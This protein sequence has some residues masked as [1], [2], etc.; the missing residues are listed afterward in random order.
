[1]STGVG[2][3]EGDSAGPVGDASWR[4]PAMAAESHR[5]TSFEIFFDL[6]FVFAITR[7]VSFMARSLTAATLAQGLI[8]LLLLWWSWAAY[9]WLGNRVRTDQGVVRAGMLVVM[10]AL[11]I[12]ALVMPDAWSRRTGTV[13][14]PLILAAA[15]IVVRL[16]YFGL[17]LTAAAEDSGLRV[18]LLA[19]AIPQ[20]LSLVPLIAGAVLAGTWQTALWSVAF[21]IDFG[22]GWIASRVGGWRVRSPGHFAERH[23]MVLIIVL[24]ESL[25]SAGAGAGDSVTR[26][27]VLVAAV[28]GFA[29]VVCLWRLYFERLAPAAEDTLEH[30]SPARRA[31]IA[32]DAYTM[33][34]FL[35]I[36]GILYL[37]LGAREVLTAVTDSRASNLGA[38]LS[39]PASTALYAGTAGY[40][41]GRAA[42]TRLTVRQVP[43]AQPAAAAALLILLPVARYL[44]ALA[45]LAVVSATLI[46]L[47]AFEGA[48][49]EPDDNRENAD[50]HRPTDA[51]SASSSERPGTGW[52]WKQGL[53]KGRTRRS[54][55][56]SA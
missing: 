22:G 5:V 25:I 2:P 32:R 39:W 31:R 12:A 13:D 42:F 50:T 14:A 9:V 34:H 44:P 36:A 48:A 43:P 24:G 7:V 26:T 29:A 47:T 40:L 56:P 4:R 54:A 21:A 33:V 10:A 18:Q 6:V 16:V 37:A 17:Y 45:A 28:L 8:L 51:A 11:F 3:G 41:A 19:D 30:A 20:T 46:A 49:R 15:F 38:P 1:M 35:L 27:M 52:E 23:R 55:P 53:D